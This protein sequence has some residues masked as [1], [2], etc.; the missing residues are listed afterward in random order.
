[1]VII[2][3]FLSDWNNW[4]GSHR[5]FESGWNITTMTWLCL[6]LVTL[7]NH[8]L[9]SFGNF[10]FLW[11]E[12]LKDCYYIR[13]SID[14]IHDSY[15]KKKKS[16]SKIQVKYGT[17]ESLSRH[18]KDSFSWER[19]ARQTEWQKQRLLSPL[20]TCVSMVSLVALFPPLV[21]LM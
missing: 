10:F 18:L 16:L 1:M 17:C 5:F 8:H 2:F 7:N 11:D 4:V 12:G 9:K 21:I 14:L 15:L 13:G 20:V 6:G 19:L 3:I